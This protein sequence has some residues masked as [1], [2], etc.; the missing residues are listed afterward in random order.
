G[1]NSVSFY[2]VDNAGNKE[3][4]QNVEVK[5]DKTAPETKSDAPTTWV[6]EADVTLTATDAQSG[7]AKTFYSLN[8]SEFKEGTTL[9]VGEEGINH[10]SFYSVDN[11]G[12]K[13]ETQIVE[14]KVDKTVPETKSDV[15]ASWVKED[16]TVKL[17]PSDSQSG[18]AKTYYTIDGSDLIDGTSF[19]L[20]QEGIH[21][22]TY[23]TVDKAGNIEATKTAQVK[24]DK[25][26]PTIFA[27]FNAEY[28]LGSTLNLTYSAQDNLSGIV[29]E[30]VIFNGKKYKNGDTVTF[31]QPGEYTLSIKT[32]DAAGLTTIIEK[33]FVVY[34]L[35]QLDVLPKVI[36]GNKGIFGVLATLPKGYC[37]TFDISTVTLN[38]I[39]FT[40]KNWGL[41]KLG[42][43]G[44][45]KFERED[46]EW[47][48]GY[49]EL[50]LR[51]KLSNG[52]VFVGKTN[53][54]VKR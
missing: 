22:I 19:T 40:S 37:S 33:T 53:A 52:Y 39:Q 44:L 9:S 38:G 21:D 25:T 14:I 32:T 35:I 1:V 34:I 36:H 29:K 24:I 28:E 54:L 13:E 51:G 49:V 15:P 2:S 4:V 3:E 45:F 23:Y 12:N 48:P 30:E 31:Y 46:F 26:A 7:V 10:V 5:V 47:N 41:Q 17:T 8:G 50:E 6:K 11:A 43:F 16:V 27:N 20:S 42:E 18:I